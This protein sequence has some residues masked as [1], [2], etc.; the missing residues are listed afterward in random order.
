[1]NKGYPGSYANPRES[2][3]ALALYLLLTTYLIPVAI[4]ILITTA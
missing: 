3:T 1:M 2:Y 4:Q